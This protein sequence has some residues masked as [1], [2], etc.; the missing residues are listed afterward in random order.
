VIAPYINLFRADLSFSKLDLINFKHADLSRV[1]LNKAILQN[2]NL[3]DS[4]LFFTRLTNT[5]LEM[6][7]CTDSNMANVNF[8]N[9]NLNNC[10]FNCSVLTKAWMFNT[11]LYRVNF[12]EASV[13]GMGISIL[14][15]E[16]N[17]PINSDTLVTL[18]KFFEED[19]TSHTG[20]SQTENNTHE[21]AMKITADIMQHAD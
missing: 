20:M 17:I 6:V 11:R 10:H 4:K 15:G 3:I 18:Q 14:R 7:I 8:N 13:Q 1:N 5:F 12:D 19:C 9:A 16:E 21:V 2:I